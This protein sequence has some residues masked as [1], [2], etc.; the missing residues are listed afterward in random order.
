MDGQQEK[1][2]LLEALKKASKD[3]Q[4]NPIIPLYS[5]PNL[6]AATAIL[7]LET[8]LANL[9]SSDSSLF[10]LS[11]SLS[12]LRTQLRSLRDSQGYTLRSFIRRQIASY[13]I[14]KI[15]GT[16]ETQVQK[17][18]DQE[19]VKK[20]VQVLQ[21]SVDEDEKVDALIQFENRVSD[22]FERDLQEIILRARVFSILEWIVSDSKNSDRV[23]HEAGR[24]IVALVRFNKD[25][26]VGPVLMG[27]TVPALVSLASCGSI[28]ILS[29]LVKLIRN[30]L[31][32]EMETSDYIPRI[33]ALLSSEDLSTQVAAMECILELTYYA[34]REAIEGMLEQGLVKKLVGLQRENRG[35]RKETELDSETSEEERELIDNLPFTNCLTRFVVKLEMGEGLEQWEKRELKQEILKRARESSFSEAEATS[36]VADVLWGSSPLLH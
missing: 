19:T 25:V 4:T 2:R 3:L 6:A 23:R 15:G 34:R 28:Q 36:I 21:E 35:S 27:P 10:D 8:Q 31:V 20:L 1:L 7:E 24:A 30:P 12:N 5:A 18:V 32:Y 29:S 9:L 26:F 33:T 22:G 11:V 14:S 17:W 13:E 16:I